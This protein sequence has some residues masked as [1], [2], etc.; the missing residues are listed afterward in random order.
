ME[1]RALSRQFHGQLLKSVYLSLHLSCPAH[2][3]VCACV[4]KHLCIQFCISGC[5]YLRR[6]CA[7]GESGRAAGASQRVDISRGKDTR[8][9]LE[10]NRKLLKLS[11][12]LTKHF[13]QLHYTLLGMRDSR[14]ASASG[15]RSVWLFISALDTL[16]QL[17]IEII[18]GILFDSQ[19]SS[20]FPFQTNIPPLYFL[21]NLQKCLGS[22][23]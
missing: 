16:V 14:C 4:A 7:G 1:H 13:L 10:R 8:L 15:I 19:Y 5:P 2:A 22:I 6:I 17:G 18:L 23:Y 12:K 11:L 3:S 9:S 21:C 20:I